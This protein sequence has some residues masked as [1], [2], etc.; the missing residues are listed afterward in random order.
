MKKWMSLL[1]SVLLLV[2][3]LPLGVAADSYTVTV[4]GLEYWIDE[5]GAYLESVVDSEYYFGDLVLPEYVDGMPLI[6]ISS[7]V[8]T[9]NS[10]LYTVTI[11]STVEYIGTGAFAGCYNLTDI[12]VNAG[13]YN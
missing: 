7:Y 13:N 1:L 4:D 8:F 2:G 10:N 3:L 6:S 9:D 5:D 11:P 12:Y